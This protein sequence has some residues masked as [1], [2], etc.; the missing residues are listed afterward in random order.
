MTTIVFGVTTQYDLMY[1]DQHSGS[2]LDG[3]FYRPRAPTGWFI[4]GDYAQGSYTAPLFPSMLVRVEDDDPANPALLPPTDYIEVWSDR[5]S[6]AD[7]DGSIWQP[8]APSGYAAL[9][10]V[11][12]R[13][14]EKPHVASLRCVR[15]DLLTTSG[16]ACPLIWRDEDSGADDNVAVYAIVGLSTFWAVDDYTTPVTNP[17]V[18]ARPPQINFFPTMSYT[19]MYN[20]HKSDADLDGAFWRPAPPTTGWYIVGDYAQGDYDPPRAPS[21]CICITG[22]DAEHPLLASPTGYAQIWKDTDS[23]AEMDGSLWA[24]LAPSGYVALG[25]VGQTGYTTPSIATLRCVRADLVQTSTTGSLIWNSEGSGADEEVEVYSI[26]GMSTFYAQGNYDAPSGTVYVL[27]PAYHPVVT[28]PWAGVV[29]QTLAC[30]AAVASGS[31]ATVDVEP[32]G[33]TILGGHLYTVS[34]AGAL[35]TTPA[36][37]SSGI[38]WVSQVVSPSADDAKSNDFESITHNS[39][40]LFVGVEGFAAESAARAD[41]TEYTMPKIRQFVRSP[42][43]PA[44]GLLGAFALEWQLEVDQA[45]QKQNSGMEGLTFVPDGSYPAAWLTGSHYYTGPTYTPAYGGLFFIALQSRPGKLFVYDLPATPSGPVAAIGVID[46]GLLPLKVS[47][48]CFDAAS[49]RLFVLYDASAA[50]DDSLQ[51]LIIAADATLGHDGTPSQGF[52]SLYADTIPYY[53][54]EGVTVQGDDLYLAVDLG[55]GQADSAAPLPDGV[56]LFPGLV[57]ALLGA[58]RAT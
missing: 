31:T 57:P 10:C 25:A 26:R 17:H 14:Y 51:I 6:G 36:A 49:G 28:T 8:V 12:T 18:L 2:E 30:P 22:D 32:S 53:G 54:C 35:L 41:A 37:K 44:N 19:L 15:L 34:D 1:S 9:G 43:P 29:P 20:D 3:A 13:G 24:P 48:L 50:A 16:L 7:L 27:T 23:G 4:L 38:H 55:G 21:L 45:D 46:A 47:D 33:L 58:S 40:Y 56:Y 52:D 11:A 39:T 42:F 5:D